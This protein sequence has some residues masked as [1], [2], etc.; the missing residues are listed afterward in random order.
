MTSEGERAI[1]K[2]LNQV[3]IQL[4]VR[5]IIELQK[6]HHIQAD[7]EIPEVDQ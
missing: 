4:R 1:A 5:N 6:S 2:A 3:A 7:C